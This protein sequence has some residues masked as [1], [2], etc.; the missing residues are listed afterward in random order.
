MR[1]PPTGGS[2]SVNIMSSGLSHTT[3][4]PAVGSS[5]SLYVNPVCDLILPMC[6]VNP[7]L[8]LACIILSAS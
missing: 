1:S 2:T 3:T 7:K 4:L 8:S 5:S 6:G